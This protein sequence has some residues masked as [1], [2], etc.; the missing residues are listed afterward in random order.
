MKLL[1]A[2]TKEQIKYFLAN[3]GVFPTI[4]LLR[5]SPAI[6]GWLKN[7]A[8][9]V[10]PAPVKRMIIKSYLKGYRL[11]HFVETGTFMGDTLAYI[12]KD[13]SIR[14]LSIELDND[15]YSRAVH[16]FERWRNVSLL[17][18]DSGSLISD[19]VRGLSEP[20][21][22]WLDGHYSGGSTAR[23][24]SETP[25]SYELEII[26]R[27]GIEGHVILIDDVRCFDGTHD[28]PRLESLLTT[29]RAD[30]RYDIEVSADIL[31]LTPKQRL[32]GHRHQSIV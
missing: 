21:L 18:G 1:V 14:A 26:L 5:R 30:G 2:M 15:L 24:D 29:I 19:V 31:R 10:A 9:D 25:L 11:K 8:R 23:G 20:T 17:R 27:S 28:Y 12:A 6:W 16:R 32:I 3:I 7:G 4:D 22:F 13:P